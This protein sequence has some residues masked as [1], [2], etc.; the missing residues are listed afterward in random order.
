[1]PAGMN[2]SVL[3]PSGPLWSSPGQFPAALAV[4]MSLTVLASML[5]AG[6]MVAPPAA[7]AT[8]TTTVP[9]PGSVRTA[10]LAAENDANVAVA[11]LDT[12]TGSYYGSLAATDPFPAESVVKVLIA[13]KLLATGQMT[14]ST[15]QLAYQMITQSDD[16]AADTLWGQ[17]GGPDVVGWAAQRYGI[18]DLGSPPIEYDWWG[19]TKLTAR[20]MV[21]LYAA[22]KADPVVGPWLLNAMGNMST[23]AADG[24][25]QRFGLA[26]QTSVGDFKQGW[27]GD[28]DSF[29]SE[30]LNSTGLLDGGRF[31]VA[32]FVQHL[33]YEPMS[34]LLPAIDEVAAAVAPGGTVVPPVP[35]APPPAAAVPAATPP[36]RPAAAPT[37]NRSLTART[38]HSDAPTHTAHS[39]AQQHAVMSRLSAATAHLGS[40]VSWLVASAIAVAGVV[41]VGAAVAGRHR[42][43]DRRP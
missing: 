21:E 10:V 2:A 30:Q 37:A 24:T 12:A 27:G 38:P 7:A 5:A 16:D 40:G 1:M 17:V 18:T 29:D 33:P 8:I 39:P 3:P 22:I 25:D 26:A 41:L 14:G 35:V 31:A 23:V 43:P 6:L 15:E 34:E 19:N 36:P 20:G 4:V 9:L 13:A 32:I 11:V 28:D 42:R